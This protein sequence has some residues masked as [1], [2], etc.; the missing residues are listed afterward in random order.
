MEEMVVQTDQAGQDRESRPVENL[1]AG[2][3]RDRRRGAPIRI[4]PAAITTV[5]PGRAGAPVPSITVT[6]TNAT[7]ESVTTTEESRCCTSN[8]S[9]ARSVIT[10]PPDETVAQVYLER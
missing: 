5:C 9:P 10:S 1:G 3:N 6:P 4:R 8:E 7:T 2:K